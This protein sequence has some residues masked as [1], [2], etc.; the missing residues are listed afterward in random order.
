MK[1][2]CYPMGGV[3]YSTDEKVVGKWIDSKPLYQKTIDCGALPNATQK[4]ISIGVSDIDKVINYWGFATNGLAD[5]FNIS[6]PAPSSIAVENSIMVTT[7]IYNGV[8]SIR[9]WTGADQS[10]LSGYITVQYTK[11]TD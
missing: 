6:L 11:T 5:K 1:N 4:Y 9:I 8:H 2:I 7:A 10:G 3:E